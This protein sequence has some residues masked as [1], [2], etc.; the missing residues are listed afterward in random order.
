MDQPG[1][2]PRLR[3]SIL[4]GLPVASGL[5][6]Y[7]STLAAWTSIFV[8]IALVP[9]CLLITFQ[10][11]RVRLYLG[12][13]LG[14]L[15][16][17]L[18]GMHWLRY[19]DPSAWLGWLLLAAYL[20]LYF[21]AFLLLAR[22]W[23]RRWKMPLLLAIPITWVA[24]EYV[25]MHLMTGMGWLLLAHSIYQWTWVI[26][27]ADFAGVFGVSLVIALVN[28]LFTELLTTPLYVR[29]DA[30]IP[31]S[32]RHRKVEHLAMVGNPVIRWR[33]KFTLG[34]LIAV[35]TYG[36]FR[37]WQ[38]ETT[39]GPRVVLI[40]TS[41]PQSLKNQ[42]P[43]ETFKEV[44]DLTADVRDLDADL[45]IW[46]ETS[47][48]FLYGH[49][50]PQLSDL[51]V[52]RLRIA[53]EKSDRE[54]SEESGK[55][56]RESL[57]EGQRHLTNL[58]DQLGSPLLVGTIRYHYA[59]GIAHLYNSSVLYVPE[60]GPVAYYDKIHLVPFGEYMPLKETLP[61]LRR[62]MPYEEGYDFSLDHATRF[63]TLHYEN[64]HFASL[65]CFEDT[66]PHIAR[67]FLTQPTEQHPID[68]FVNQSNDGW[69]RGSI[70]A[71]YHLAAS[72]FRCVECRL[73]MV[74][75][76][77]T[78]ITALVDSYGTVQKAFEHN[79]RRT[80]IRGGMDAV[81]PLDSRTPPYVTF[82]DWLPQLC[83][84]VSLLGFLMST[85]RHFRIAYR[86]LLGN[87]KAT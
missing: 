31:P 19:C 46:P 81:I 33:V 45:F 78:G 50:D 40:Q 69:F 49:V 25:R 53:D 76:S 55:K 3:T 43:Q 67:G 82:G 61:I 44:L 1:V 64:L 63:T 17:Y 41:I 47:Y 74:R 84:A 77:N 28:A 35:L 14:G 2:S 56:L 12:A 8:W 23:H 79:G 24:L 16:F 80:N 38:T 39:P 66:L 5:L 4:I 36:S 15:A 71:H 26:Q 7:L 75:V 70:E 54:P 60:K 9:L 34:V 21:P 37:G 30:N 73:P 32:P 42:D 68:F 22:I 57:L 86:R 20:A 62:L 51:E 87:P 52:D 29:A 48:P 83:L 59:P 13:Y 72:I 65:I 58:T 85:L 27:I 6:L 18:P 11:S 10:A